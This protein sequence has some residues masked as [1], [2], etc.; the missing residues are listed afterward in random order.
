MFLKKIDS[1]TSFQFLCGPP[2]VLRYPHTHT[3]IH[4]HTHMQTYN[5]THVHTHSFS[6]VHT[7]AHT[8]TLSLSFSLSL[9]LSLSWQNPLDCIENACWADVWVFFPSFPAH[10]LPPSPPDWRP[11][12]PRRSCCCGKIL[13]CRI[14]SEFT[15]ITSCTADFENVYQNMSCDPAAIH[16]QTHA[17]CKCLCMFLHLYMCTFMYFYHLPECVMWCWCHPASFADRLTCNIYMYIY[18]CTYIY[19]YIHAYIYIYINHT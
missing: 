17:R 3:H 19:T 4:T 8:H 15:T 2:S 13:K 10:P 16:P 9:S 18:V 1:R 5:L 12:H 6:H 11:H 14:A 7:Y